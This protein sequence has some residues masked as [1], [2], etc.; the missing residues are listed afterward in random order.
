MD[1]IIFIVPLLTSFMAMLTKGRF[2]R[3]RDEKKIAIIEVIID[4]VKF[5]LVYFMIILANIIW[6]IGKLNFAAMSVDI[7]MLILFFIVLW[8]KIQLCRKKSNIGNKF[9]HS[10]SENIGSHN[11]QNVNW[12]I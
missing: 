9:F 2:I 3:F 12:K 11:I 10:A 6:K 1:L 4:I 7:I 8:K 5:F